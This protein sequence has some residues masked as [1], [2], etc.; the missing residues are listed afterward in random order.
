MRHKA[1]SPCHILVSL[2]LIIALALLGWQTAKS[3]EMLQKHGSSAYQHAATPALAISSADVKPL[4]RKSGA[5]CPLVV[6]PGAG[7]LLL[8]G[9]AP[10]ATRMAQRSVLQL[11]RPE[12]A[13][14]R[15]RSPP[16]IV[17]A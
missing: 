11:C 3:E 16:R 6:G 2:L 17:T 12:L 5:P 13:G 15:G 1:D 7:Q 8:D 9:T 4:A 10:V 14:V